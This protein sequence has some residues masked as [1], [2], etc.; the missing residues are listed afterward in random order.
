MIVADASTLVAG[1]SHAGA[2]RRRL[3]SDPVAIPHLA[4]TE[5][6]HT[7]RRQVRGGQLEA[8][9]AAAMLATLAQLGLT[10]HPAL[11]LLGRT[12]QL[13]DNLSAYD[14]TYVA[15]A[16]ALDVP[17]VTLDARIAGA[18]GL[19]TSVEVLPD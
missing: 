12:W 14:A 8:H 1:L 15:L 13:R 9:Q 5:V 3:G 2:A 19:R 4:D 16:E 11:G 17:L 7:L 18:P 6:T 10:R